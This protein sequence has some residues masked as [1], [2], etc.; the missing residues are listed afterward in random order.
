MKYTAEGLQK[1]GK[2]RMRKKSVYLRFFR[3]ISGACTKR[4]A[5]RV[6]PHSEIFTGRRPVNACWELPKPA[7]LRDKLSQ[8][9]GASA[10]CC[11]PELTLLGLIPPVRMAEQIVDISLDRHGLPHLPLGLPILGI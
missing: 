5:I 8:S 7:G 9:P 4:Q 6:W 2:R 10:C 11:G 3:T 1:P